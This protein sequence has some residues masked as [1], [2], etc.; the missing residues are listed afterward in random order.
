MGRY[1]VAAN[2]QVNAE[3]VVYGAGE[4]LSLPTEEA[5]PL[6]AAGTVAQVLD[7]PTRRARV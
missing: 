3:G 7:K 1:V 6:L 2:T 4:E 5:A